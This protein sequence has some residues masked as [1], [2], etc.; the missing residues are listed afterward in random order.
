[1]FLLILCLGIWL[2]NFTLSA[3]YEVSYCFLS[4]RVHY[5]YSFPSLELIMLVLCVR[6]YL[7][8]LLIVDRNRYWFFI[9][10]GIILKTSLQLLNFIGK[11]KLLLR[12]ID[13][14]QHW[15]VILLDPICNQ[16]NLLRQLHLPRLFLIDRLV[17]ILERL[18]VF[19]H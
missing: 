15:I 19:L 4:R 13:I 10:I 14:S 3:V 18:A 5:S 7:R 11:L 16:A 12:K 9:C 17:L 6:L 8:H 2:L 1:M